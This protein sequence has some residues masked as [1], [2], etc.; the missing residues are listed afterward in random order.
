MVKKLEEKICVII[1]AY[2]EGS[3]IGN[4]LKSLPKRMTIM[5]K[6]YQVIPVIIDDGS[7]DDTSIVAGSIRGTVVVKHILNS[8]AGAATRTGLSYAKLHKEFAYAATMDADGQHTASDLKQVILAVAKEK[9]NLIIGSRLINSV[10]MPWYKVLGNK[11]LSFFTFLLLGV[12]VSDSQS[13][14]KGL[15]R[16]AIDNLTYR[17][18]GYAFCSEM[19]WRAH[20]SQLTISEIPIQAVYTDYSKAKGQSNWNAF[21]ILKQLIKHRVLDII[22]E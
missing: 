16:K 3:V 12:S 13:G 8:G 10:G 11:G 2:N 19:L 4:V 14:L 21:Q 9:N 5:K 1:P 15:D 6:T 22:Y 18:N 17:D 7:T 20:R